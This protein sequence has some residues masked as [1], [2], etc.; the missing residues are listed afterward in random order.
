MTVIREMAEDRQDREYVEYINKVQAELGASL[1]K[2]WDEDRFIRGIREDGVV[3]GARTD[4]EASMWLNPQ[5]WGV[6]SGFA[7]KEQAEI[8]MEKVHEILNTPYGVK[9]LEPP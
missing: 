1:E 3:V 5:S 7:S 6:I 2:C 4:K 8:S 9:I